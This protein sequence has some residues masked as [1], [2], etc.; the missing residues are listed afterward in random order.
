MA[1]TPVPQECLL[2]PPNFLIRIVDMMPQI[3][4]SSRNYGTNTKFQRSQVIFTQNKRFFWPL[5]KGFGLLIS[6][7]VSADF[8]IATLENETA[9]STRSLDKARYG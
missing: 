3:S 4:S 2:A 6:A 8:G 7:A 9:Y 5:F 1:K